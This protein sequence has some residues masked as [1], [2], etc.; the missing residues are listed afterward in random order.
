MKPFLYDLTAS[1][2]LFIVLIR[3]LKISFYLILS[4]YFHI[5][6][7]KTLNAQ[8]SDL[9]V[10]RNLFAITAAKVVLNIQLASLY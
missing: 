10:E 2:R 1:W 7:E 5:K 4:L 9:P 3:L 6:H 8:L